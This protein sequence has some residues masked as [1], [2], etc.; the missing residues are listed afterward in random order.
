M[1]YDT[2]VL[3]RLFCVSNAYDIHLTFVS[4]ICNHI[5]LNSE[6]LL[7]GLAINVALFD[8]FDVFSKSYLALGCFQVVTLAT[9][10]FFLAALVG[11]QYIDETT[12]LSKKQFQMEIDTYVPLFTI[13]QFFFYMGLLKVSNITLSFVA[14]FLVR[15]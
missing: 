11:R 10:S 14:K 5:N 4:Q 3:K 12:S 6:N 13:L 7:K 15:I 1:F 8:M 9:Y 2:R